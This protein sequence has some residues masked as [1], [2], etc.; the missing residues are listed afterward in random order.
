MT[1]ILKKDGVEIMGDYKMSYP[2]YTG[3]HHATFTP[4]QG[5]TD[6]V[7]KA[8]K[9]VQRDALRMPYVDDLVDVAEDFPHIAELQRAAQEE[10]W[11]DPIFKI[12]PVNLGNVQEY[13]VDQVLDRVGM[14]MEDVSCAENLL[15]LRELPMTKGLREIV[16]TFRDKHLAELEWLKGARVVV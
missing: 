5:L 1:I 13:T 9:E 11:N 8:T 10:Y 14:L 15:D 7:I 12:E 2:L 6:Q 4:P 16:E 3:A